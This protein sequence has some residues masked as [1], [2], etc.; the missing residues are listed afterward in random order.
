MATIDQSGVCV[1]SDVNT[2]SYRTHLKMGLRGN[3]HLF[4]HLLIE[5]CVCFVR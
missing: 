3:N 4:V 1:V 2:S 5:S